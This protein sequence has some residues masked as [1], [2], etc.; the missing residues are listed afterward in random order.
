MQTRSKYKMGGRHNAAQGNYPLSVSPNMLTDS[1]E[2]QRI[3]NSSNKNPK[4]L[5]EYESHLRK[6]AAAVSQTP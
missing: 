1:Q 6:M 3:L 2:Y 5:V 4:S